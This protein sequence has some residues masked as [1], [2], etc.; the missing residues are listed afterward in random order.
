MGEKIQYKL[1]SDI[2]RPKMIINFIAIDC[3]DI[4]ELSILNEVIKLME[5][6]NIDFE[7][8]YVSRDL[9]TVLEIV[10]LDNNIH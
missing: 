2:P 7:L 1:V 3:I 4:E 8:H 5:Q 10:G 9:L 6:K